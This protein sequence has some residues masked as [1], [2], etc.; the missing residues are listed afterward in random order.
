MAGGTRASASSRL[1]KLIGV[2][3]DLPI[4]DLPTNRNV[5]QQV[6][7]LRVQDPRYFKTSPLVKLART[8]G[9]MVVESWM[10]INHRMKKAI[11][12]EQEVSRRIVVLW[13]KLERAASDGKTKKWWKK[14]E[15][16]RRKGQGKTA[17]HRWPGQ[18]VRYLHLPLC[19]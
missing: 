13:Q 2:P 19:D 10:R 18:F 12:T 5:L 17:V 14:E 7:K 16:E 6:H 15:E 4:A 11:V 9:K 8:V 1:V 3:E